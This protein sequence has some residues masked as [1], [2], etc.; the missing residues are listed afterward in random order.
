MFLVLLATVFG[1]SFFKAFRLPSLWCATH[2]AFNYSQGFVR[3]GFVGEVARRLFGDDVYKYRNFTVFAFLLFIVCAV[4]FGLAVRRALRANPDDWGLRLTL[5]VFAASPGLVFFIH[6]VGYFDYLGL[7]ALLLFGLAMPRLKNRLL[8]CALALAVG[9]LFILIHEGLA[10]IFIPSL[11]FLL[12]C[13]TAR[14]SQSR[15]LETKDWVLLAGQ[16]LFIALPLIAFAVFLSTTGAQDRERV[17]RLLDFMQRHADFQIRTDAVDA[18]MRSSAYNLQHILPQYWALPLSRVRA[19]RDLSSFLPGL[20]VVIYYGIATIRRANLS[21]AIRRVVMGSFVLA[22]FSPELMNL[23]GWDW[24][25]WNG[26]ALI[27]SMVAILFCKQLLTS[28]QPFVTP[29][30]LLS[31]GAVATAISLASTQMLFD[32]YC[33]QYYP[34]D[35]QL[36]LARRI[37]AEGF[38]TRPPGI[39]QLPCL[40]N[41]QF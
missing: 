4:L 27:T 30:W 3:R 37:V 24:P 8:S 2:F 5:V 1:I 28:G 13:D 17:H 26:L 14:T 40:Q 23:V 6:L 32:N 10:V 18:L 31:L 35:I 19:A 15:N 29:R 21:V 7:L 34:F 36:D 38:N 22:A 20:A 11:L 9:A 16:A 25:R 39:P 41:S 33:V 12:V